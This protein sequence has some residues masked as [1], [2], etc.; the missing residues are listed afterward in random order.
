MSKDKF[1]VGDNL[2][3]LFIVDGVERSLTPLKANNL[4]GYGMKVELVSEKKA[5]KG[6]SSDKAV[7]G[8]SSDKSKPKSTTKGKGK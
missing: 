2:P 1:K 3:Q 6:P 5:V 7:K 8:P 4:H